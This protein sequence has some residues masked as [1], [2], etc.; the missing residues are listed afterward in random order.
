MYGAK[1]SWDNFHQFQR[2][3]E[4][5][6]S[7]A[8]LVSVLAL[9][10]ITAAWGGAEAETTDQVVMRM[11]DN[12]PDRTVTWGAV[13]EEINAEF[14]AQHP[15]VVFETESYPDQPYQEKIRIYATAGQ[16]P[17]VMKYWSFSTLMHPL[18]E[19][20]LI[21]PL[22]MA[23]LEGLD[24]LP[25]AL[26]SNMYQGQLY[27]IPVSGDLWV[28]Y[29]NQAILDEVG[30]APPR[31]F[32]ELYAA[33]PLLDAA[34]YVPMV[35]NGRDGWPLSITYDTIFWRL[36]GDYSLMRDA[37][38]GEKPFTDPEFVE[39]AEI[40]QEFFNSSGVFASDLAVT[41]YGAARNLFGAG[42]AAM[43]LMGSWE[44]GLAADTNFS[45]Q[46][47]QNVRATVFPRVSNGSGTTD[48]LVAWFGGNYIVSSA[49][50][51]M[52]LAMDYIQ[53][54]A[55]LYPNLVWARQAAFPAQT[56][57]PSQ[58]DTQVARDLLAIAADASQTSGTPALDS[59]T[60]AFKAAHE[61]LSRDLAAG[62]ITPR[63]FTAGLQEAIEEVYR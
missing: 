18:I 38:A 44:L 33:V 35:T 14:A 7:R 32:D 21:A 16:L 8:L 57:E 12:Q 55:E 10:T 23:A 37:L 13:I 59:L 43:Y 29:Y 1:K 19:S 5:M 53:T 56:V 48:Q 61:R 40:F 50:P 27:G 4:T 46:F 49:T 60:P 58:D 28:V 36:T 2:K 3:G 52:E 39:A 62:I 17:D 20:G 11:S 41:D 51:N 6:K 54:Y 42:R 25:G 22:D 45:D 63:E 24:W 30:I 34:G 47:R 31:S 15:T 9:V 26:E